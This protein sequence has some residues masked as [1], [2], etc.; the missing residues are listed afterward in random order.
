MEEFARLNNLRGEESAK[1]LQGTINKG[2]ARPVHTDL[3]INRQ[4]QSGD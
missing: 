3:H 1:G 2:R 4:R